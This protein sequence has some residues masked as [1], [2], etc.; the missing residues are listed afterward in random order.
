MTA[1]TA[2]DAHAHHFG[3]DLPL[4]AGDAPRLVL[5]GD[6]GRI[7]RGENTFRV[8]SPVLWDVPRRLAEMD[9]AGISHQVISPVPVA[10]EYAAEQPAYAAATNDSIAS[11]CEA[12]GGRLFGL[13]CLPLAD[14]ESAR[15]E[16]ERCRRIG[17]RGVEIGTRVGELDLDASELDSFWAACDDL[18]AAVF[19]HPVE[20]GKGVVRRAGAPYDLGLGMLTDTAIAAS[21]L[22]FG[23]VLGRYRGLRVAL[24]HGCGVFP[25]A[26]PRLRV[27]AALSRGDT[28]EDW[29]REARRLYADTLVFDDEHLRLL[30]HRFG[31]ERLLL[32][33]DAPFFPDQ[34]AKSMASIQSGL[35]SEALPRRAGHEFL[36]ANAFEFLGLPAPNANEGAQR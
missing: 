21:A 26:Y 22:V 29:D 34:M 20:G 12:A 10:M 2:V 18:G 3:T 25:W 31:A 35:R 33:S 19:V 13:G 36:A 9:R 1:R 5:D 8:V 4:P 30:V 32:G 14:G 6:S 28:A 11:A 15:T 24:A 27:A 23:G 17:L 7:M 16:L